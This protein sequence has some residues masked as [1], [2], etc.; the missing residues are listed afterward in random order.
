MLRVGLKQRGPSDN[1]DGDSHE[2]I[3]HAPCLRQKGGDSYEF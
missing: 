1:E 3:K 2:Q